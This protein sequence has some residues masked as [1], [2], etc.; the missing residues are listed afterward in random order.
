MDVNKHHNIILAI[1]SLFGILHPSDAR[2]SLV[3]LFDYIY[4]A[5]QHNKV[6]LENQDIC[7]CICVS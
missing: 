5:R 2:K 6:M 3:L 4:V 7:G 1:V